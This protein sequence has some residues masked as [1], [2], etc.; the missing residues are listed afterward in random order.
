VDS[1]ST[2]HSCAVAAALGARVLS[3]TIDKPTAAAGRN[4]GWRASK[5]GL[6]HFIDG[7]TILEPGWLSKAVAAIQD[8][9]VA[10]AFGRRSETAPYSTVYNF[11]AHYDWYVRPGPADSC[12]G[13]A[14]FR[15]EVLE[16]AGG[17]DGTLIAGEE[18]D[19]CYRIR[20]ELGKLILSLDEP[21]T[22]H[23]MNMTRFGQYWRRCVRTGHAYAENARR[24]PHAT[25]W[26]VAVWRNTIYTVAAMAC[27]ASSLWSWSPW[28]LLFLAVFLT[29][30]V[31]RNALRFRQ[32]IQS[33]PGALLYSAHHYL[34]KLP[35]FCGQVL[36]WMR[37]MTGRRSRGLIEY[38]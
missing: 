31:T 6:V 38:R 24:H 20:S 29:F 2:D 11:W 16:A 8:P 37:A 15:R 4:V 33:M 30:A 26:R 9:N 1:N 35:I 18:P 23:D 3:L 28:P 27:L 13:D 36:F 25:K 34:S 32:Q 5:H 22:R 10:C 14:L 19:L 17:Y 7:D 12:A 21:M